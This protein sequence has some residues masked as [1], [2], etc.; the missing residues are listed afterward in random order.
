MKLNF[1][2]EG[3]GLILGIILWF[4]SS[5]RYSVINLKDKIYVHMVRMVTVLLGLNMIAYL[6]IRKNISGLMAVSE[7]I[8]SISFFAIVWIWAYI[9]HYLMEAIYNKNSFSN[10]MYFIIGFPAFLNLLLVL[11]NVG[12]HMIF[13]VGKVKGSIQVVFNSWYKVPYALAAVSLV[14]YLMIMMSGQ[15]KLREKKQYVFFLI[16][17]VMLIIYY[18]QYR[19]K[20]IAILGFGYSIILLL[21]YIYNYNYTVQ[22]DYLT[23]L[24]D[25]DKFKK[26]LEYRVGANQSMIVAM[27]ALDDFK[28]VN[29]E[30]GYSNGDLFL[31]AIAGY[32]EK[33]APKQCLL[34][35]SGDKFAV[36]FDNST[37]ENV[38]EWCK[39]VLG[40]FEHSWKVGNLNHKLSVCITLVKYPEQAESSK[41]ILELLEYLNTYAKRH[42]KNQYIVCNDEFKDKMRRR[43]RITDILNEMIQESRITV[44]YQ[45]ILE[46]STNTY[47]RAETVLRLR[48]EQ[49]GD[50]LSEEFLPI[51]EENGF[52]VEIGYMIIDQIC[53][54]IVSIKEQ[55]IQ[56]PI[57][58]VNFSRQQIMAEDVEQRITEILKKYQLQPEMIAIELPEEAFSVQFE[59]VKA[60]MIRLNEKGVRFYL[61]GFGMG[62]LD[63]SHLMD[64]P[65]EIIK[66]DKKMIKEAER[67]DSIY[68]LVSAMN[69]VF[70]ES[71]KMILGDGIE[72]EHLKEMADLLFMH[73][74]QGSYLCEPMSGEQARVEFEKEQVAA[75][76][77][78]FEGFIASTLEKEYLPS[79]Q[80][81]ENGMNDYGF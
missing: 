73:Y 50:I 47:T 21:L 9:C 41:E 38:E 69:A 43:L 11:A 26:M 65:F 66:I 44:E 10:G 29:Q 18:F 59:A 16:P 42:K 17:F 27:I 72:S 56:V 13:D 40:R 76:M 6:I 64:L 34:R 8:I 19:F 2:L 12:T 23:H 14:I 25:G 75:D 39:E 48:D 77:S 63:I 24:P 81:I 62:F 46:V 80:A 68:L 70:E 67:K 33:Q 20:S 49:M 35:Y 22:M 30:Y 4:A 61:D 58:S 54:Y 79:E 1:Y 5:M 71:G 28:R 57:V 15:K 78:D 53:R 37:D 7:I 52:L 55:G 45:P 74:L 51:A 60:Q 36:V 31:K 32:L 3:A